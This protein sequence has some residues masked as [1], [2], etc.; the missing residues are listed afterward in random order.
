MCCTVLPRF[1]SGLYIDNLSVYSPHLHFFGPSLF[2]WLS[3]PAFMRFTASRPRRL[4]LTLKHLLTPSTSHVDYNAVMCVFT[5][6]TPSP[7]TSIIYG[8]TSSARSQFYF[9]AAF[10]TF[11]GFWPAFA[12]KAIF[13]VSLFSWFQSLINHT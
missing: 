12:T 2:Q 4:L 3:R 8:G 13:M 10:S 7:F 1:H 5:L 6:S 9:A 11:V